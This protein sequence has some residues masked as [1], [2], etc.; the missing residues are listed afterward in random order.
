MIKYHCEYHLRNT[1]SVV[2]SSQN[3]LDHPFEN[4]PEYSPLVFMRNLCFFRV[5]MCATVNFK[6][7][8][9]DMEFHRAQGLLGLR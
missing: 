1:A 2:W 8:V 5:L 7:C 9:N 4:R 6:V 3:K